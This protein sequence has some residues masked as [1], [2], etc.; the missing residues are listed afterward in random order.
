LFNRGIADLNAKRFDA[1][2]TD[3]RRRCF[4][5]RMNIPIS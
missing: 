1:G 4:T 3:F 2:V 5:R